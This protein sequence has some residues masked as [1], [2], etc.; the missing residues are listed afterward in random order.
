MLQSEAGAT[1]EGSCE[2]HQHS[3]AYSVPEYLSPFARQFR[4][5][6]AGVCVGDLDGRK[7]FLV[8]FLYHAI[9]ITVPGWSIQRWLGPAIEVSI[10]SKI[11][12][13]CKSLM[14]SGFMKC[15]LHLKYTQMAK[16]YTADLQ[17]NMVLT[18][19]NYGPSGG[20]ESSDCT[21]A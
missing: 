1:V 3:E 16:L 13:C 18:G 2:P 10:L 11:C 14:Q 5:H 19:N 21:A 20:F 12:I 9:Q 15:M 4:A 7:G 6:C 8:C 17:A